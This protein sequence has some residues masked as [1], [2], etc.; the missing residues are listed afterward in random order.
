MLQQRLHATLMKYVETLFSVVWGRGGVQDPKSK[1]S[2]EVRNL[3]FLVRKQSELL[4]ESPVVIFKESNFSVIL[5]ACDFS[6][7]NTGLMCCI[8]GPPQHMKCLNLKTD[9][10]S[11]SFSF[12]C[13]CILPRNVMMKVYLWQHVLSW[14]SFYASIIILS[15][16]VN[17]HLHI[18]LFFTN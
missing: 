7:N 18:S 12:V 1:H 4:K 3:F 10:F 15:V 2:S 11:C 5:A 13:F 9:F 16:K 6:C 14:L 17:F 8:L